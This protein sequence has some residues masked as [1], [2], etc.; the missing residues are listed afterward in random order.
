MEIFVIE[1][2]YEFK[3]VNVVC[4]ILLS[5]K[6]EVCLCILIGELCKCWNV[7]GVLVFW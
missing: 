7:L 4:Q 2:V 6:E 3:S 5:E 1:F